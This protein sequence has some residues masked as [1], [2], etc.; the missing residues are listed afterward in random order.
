MIFEK[1]I[2]NKYFFDSKII[3]HKNYANNNSVNCLGVTDK[4][5][6]I[7]TRQEDTEFITSD[8]KNFKNFNSVI[9]PIHKSIIKKMKTKFDYKIILIARFTNAYMSNTRLI[10]IMINEKKNIMYNKIKK[11]LREL[12]K[13]ETNN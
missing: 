3:I 12:A 2:Y 6:V 5:C 11:N 4:F 9:T 1:N 7:S 10:K 8:K 13:N